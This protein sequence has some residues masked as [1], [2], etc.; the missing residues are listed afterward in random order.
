MKS[1]QLT[2]NRVTETGC[3]TPSA[4]Q[5]RSTAFTLI[6]LLVVIAIIAI[7][8]AMLL[9]TLSRGKEAARRIACVNNMKNL[10]LALNMYA[11]EMEGEYPP[12]MAPFWN[13]RLQPY[14]ENTN[15]LRCPSDKNPALA[16]SYLFNGF[17]DYFEAHLDSTNYTAFKDH[18][19]PGGLKEAFI[20]ESSETITFGQKVSDSHHYHMDLYQGNHEAQIEERGH[21][22]GSNGRGTDSVYAFADGSARVLRPGQ[23]I[24]PINLWAITDKWRTNSALFMT[25]P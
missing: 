7:L 10:G 2:G 12:R 4:Q 20:R 21:G 13:I 18:L 17:D 22:M 8:A 25:T 1:K 6:E 9:P 23:A 5:P 24:A 19:W 16:R 11:D 3:W 14:F 15:I